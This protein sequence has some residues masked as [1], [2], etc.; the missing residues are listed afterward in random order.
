MD[1][2]PVLGRMWEYRILS[3]S[4]SAESGDEF[5]VED[6]QGNLRRRYRPTSSERNDEDLGYQDMEVDE[7][8]DS[9]QPS[10]GVIDRNNPPRDADW[11]DMET[12]LHHQKE[13]QER[14]ARKVLSY[15][16]FP[17]TLFKEFL[18]TRLAAEH[19]G[20]FPH[21]AFDHILQ[22]SSEERKEFAHF[23]VM[24]CSSQWEDDWD[25]HVRRYIESGEV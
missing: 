21:M 25:G 5:F 7:A 15:G 2:N 24:V 8:G 17:E 6:A 16:L 22:W 23:A 9:G 18:R 4:D 11:W 19:T 3:G 20:R 13:E 12:L 1:W 10:E 14:R